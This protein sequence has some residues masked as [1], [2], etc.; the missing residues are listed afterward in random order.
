MTR[1]R[2]TTACSDPDHHKVHAPNCI[3]SFGISAH[4]PQVRRPVADAGR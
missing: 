1:C 2:L 4:A 3:A